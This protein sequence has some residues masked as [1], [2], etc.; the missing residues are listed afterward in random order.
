MEIEKKLKDLPSS[1]GVYIMKGKKGEVLYIGKAKNLR[2][3]VRS[4]FRSTETSG[5]TRYAVKYLA[6]K[7]SDI[8]YIVT[9][10]EKEALILEDTMLKKH[11]P[12]YN[13]RLKDDKTYLSIKITTGEPFP[14][15]F[16]TRRIIKDGARYF[17]PYASASMAKETV[18]FLR[19]I[20]PLCVCSPAE[21]KNRMRPCLDYQLGIC[22][23]P[24]VD[25]IS[26]E[27]YGEIVT[28]AILFLEGKNRTLVKSLKS[29][30]KEASGALAFEE[31]VK[32][33]DRINAIEAT[34]EE[35][36]VISLK[37]HDQDVIAHARSERSL[38]FQVL[39]IRD[40]RLTGGYDYAFVDTLL[41]ASDI[42]SSF[43]AQY[44]RGERFI[45]N[46]VLTE[47]RIPD[48]SF[49]SEWL[50]EK[51]GRKVS[52]IHPER[53]FKVK[54][55]KMAEDNAKETLRKKVA[56][57][58]DSDE[59]ISSLQK[60]LRLKKIPSRIEAFDISNIGGE[61]A[62][63]AMVTF[64]GGKPDK[65]SYRRFK[66]KSV[67]GADDYAMIFEVLS[68]R[69]GTKEEPSQL[70][71]P[72]LILIDGGR[73]QLS[74]A[75]AALKELKITGVELCALAK[76]K[77]SKGDGEK[78]GERVFRPNRKNPVELKEGSKPDLLLRAIRDEVHR[79]A[80]TYHRKVRKKGYGS[81][82]EQVPGVGA[83]KRTALFSRFGSIKEIKEASIEEL[84]EL[85][86]ITDKIAKKIKETLKEKKL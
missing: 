72:D 59:L 47:E 18:K 81:V 68:R 32:L 75:E 26:E 57:L 71:L 54:L 77:N 70:P 53:G 28:G 58:S 49:L 40:G 55:L 84:M 24:A 20:F 27:A 64:A 65:N 46:E 2:S 1:P 78:K 17:G 74:V 8:D 25:L 31:A 66:I 3:R 79:F 61:S 42:F 83:K 37:G 38:V 33:R 50:T 73:G 67:E 34:L 44:Y 11:R 51:K 5:D 45:P 16:T 56:S 7:T 15:I 12:R 39:T 41:P 82:L 14:R 60:R 19:R 86:G 76:E 48:S 30:M 69:Y 9:G 23:A 80:I 22:A 21:F 62:V 43:I 13:I 10:N 36:K 4:Y 35:Q 52:I 6:G 85:S 29:K 63:G